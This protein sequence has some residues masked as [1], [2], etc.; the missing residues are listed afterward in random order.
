[1]IAGAP[2]ESSRRSAGALTREP[3]MGNVRA[4]AADGVEGSFRGADRLALRRSYPRENAA[5][6]RLL[7]CKRERSR[8]R[9]MH[10][11]CVAPGR[12]ILRFVAT[13]GGSRALASIDAH[14][15]RSGYKQNQ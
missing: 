3:K 10:T 4:R 2:Q 11:H 1:V 15:G 12:D 7:R 9:P 13:G 5:K 6:Q 8:S 14:F